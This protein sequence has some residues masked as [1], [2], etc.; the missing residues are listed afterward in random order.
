MQALSNLRSKLSA[1]LVAVF[2]CFSGV[3]VEA[4]VGKM[5]AET[6]SP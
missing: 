4:S 6:M 1:Y 5:L 2:E 3:G